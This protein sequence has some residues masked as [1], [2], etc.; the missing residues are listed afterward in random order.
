M[1]WKTRTARTAKN[2]K[3]EALVGAHSLRASSDKASLR[4]KVVT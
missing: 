4:A 2:L 1:H 3:V